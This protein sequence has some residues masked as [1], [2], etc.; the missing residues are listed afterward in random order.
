MENPLISI[1]MPVKNAAPYIEECIQSIIKQTFTNWELIAINDHSTDSSTEII[2][3]HSALD[4]RIKLHHNIDNGIIAALKLAYLKSNGSF[5]TRMDADDI[6][7]L[8][9]LSALLNHLQVKG[10]GWVATGCV[11]YFSSN[12]NLNEGYQQYENWINA[13]TKK[14]NNYTQIYKEC[15]IPSPCWMLN[16]T[17]FDKIGAF[18]SSIYPED[19]DLAFRI[20]YGGIQITG[21]KDVLH[22]WRDYPERTSRNDPNYSNNAFPLIKTHYFIKHELKNNEDLILWGAGKKAKAIA[23][24]FI[25]KKII[26]RWITNNPKKIGKEIYGKKIINTDKILINDN[27]QVII[28]IASKNFQPN[29]LKATNKQIYRFC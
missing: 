29:F 3:K 9:K 10:K 6:M 11:K 28:A 19:Y 27:T 23:K 12:K 7:S 13:L 24:I 25:G 1:L 18:N 21:V 22:L 14:E 16:K 20:Y 8:N 26:F 4:A 15:V 5:I 17:D 2:S